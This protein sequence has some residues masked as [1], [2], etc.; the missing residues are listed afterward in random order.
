MS[1]VGVWVAGV[2]GGGRSG[3]RVCGIGVCGGGVGAFMAVRSMVLVLLSSALSY[4]MLSMHALPM[5]KK[6]GQKFSLRFS[7][8]LI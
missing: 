1:D 8:F 7:I 5:V 6:F 2:R 3:A 4:A